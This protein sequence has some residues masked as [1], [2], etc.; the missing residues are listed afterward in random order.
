MIC[1]AYTWRWPGDL[2]L[3]EGKSDATLPAFD[4]ANLTLV[5]GW[6]GIALAAVA[7]TRFVAPMP[8]RPVAGP[9]STRQGAMG[10]M[11][12]LGDVGEA[13]KSGNVA[14]L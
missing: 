3:K 2:R 4:T 1:R 13:V 12:V 10:A 6:I 14:A 5:E 9:R 11:Y 8:P 7:L